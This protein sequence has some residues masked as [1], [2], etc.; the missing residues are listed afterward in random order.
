[1]YKTACFL[2]ETGQI[3]IDYRNWGFLC[4]YKTEV[5]CFCRQILI[6]VLCDNVLCCDI[7]GME[8]RK[9]KGWSHSASSNIIKV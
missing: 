3:S 8:R 4:T 1:M 7:Y 6:L 9:L 5:L 2:E